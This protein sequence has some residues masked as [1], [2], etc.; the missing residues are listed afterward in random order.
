MACVNDC[1]THAPEAVGAPPATLKILVAGGF[2]A[3]KTTFVGA[4]SEIEPLSTEELLS[5]VGASSDPLHGVEEKTTTTVALDFGRITLD[6]RHVLYLF[7]T[8]GQHRF[9]FL[10][11]ELCAGALG[12]VVLADTRRL[13]DCFPAVDFFE[14]RGIAFIVAVN[15]FDGGH[16]Y[17]PDE[18][19]EAVGLGPEVP[20]V[21]CDA[22]LASS[23]TGALAA[24]VRHL[25]C[26]STA[27]SSSSES[28]EPL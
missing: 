20:V 19:R 5:G 22:R 8:P 15:E 4:V 2:G 6:E 17:G 3:G 12:A 26:M 1:D 7:G 28:G 25:L 10:W 14:R 23:G 24:L 11:E 18:V 13:A 16:R 21:R 27:S 9:W